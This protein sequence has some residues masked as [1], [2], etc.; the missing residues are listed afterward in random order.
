MHGRRPRKDRWLVC[1]VRP[2]GC[3][4]STNTAAEIW[5]WVTGTTLR[6]QWGFCVILFRA[7]LCSRPDSNNPRYT[8]AGTPGPSA[9]PADIGTVPQGVWM[10]GWSGHGCVEQH[11]L[12]ALQMSGYNASGSLPDDDVALSRRV[13]LGRYNQVVRLLELTPIPFLFLIQISFASQISGWYF[14]LSSCLRLECAE[15][16]CR[17]ASAFPL[18]DILVSI[19]VVHCVL[20][21]PGLFK[22]L[23]SRAHLQKEGL[24]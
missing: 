10:A 16:E 6:L 5:G 18:P 7:T 9:L 4:A 20:S 21:A 8:C 23:L 24:P 17:L 15:V 12:R 14:Y 11:A 13:W 3:T 2:A 1:P 22:Q 19:Q